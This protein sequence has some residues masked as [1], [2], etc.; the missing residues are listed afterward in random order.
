M[1]I[2]CATPTS[3]SI[4]NM[5]YFVNSPFPSKVTPTVPTRST[6]TL[7]AGTFPP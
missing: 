2:E 6:G 4:V 3:G 1:L 7:A 5:P